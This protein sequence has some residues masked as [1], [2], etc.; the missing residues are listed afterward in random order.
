MSALQGT[1]ILSE[2]KTNY[3]SFLPRKPFEG[4]YP[5]PSEIITGSSHTFVVDSRTRNKAAYPNPAKYRVKIEPSFKNVTS[6]ELKGSLI[7]KTEG[8]VNSDNRYIPFNVVDSITN[9]TSN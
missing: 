7:P 2:D 6:I 1:G 3:F 9:I 8:N 4:R 5:N